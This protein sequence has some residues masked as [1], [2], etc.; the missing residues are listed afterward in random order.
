MQRARGS[1]DDVLQCAR[2]QHGLSRI[3][4]VSEPVL[5]TSGTISILPRS[6][7]AAP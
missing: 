3:E 6:G 1:I 2:M 4:E 5:E 7:Q